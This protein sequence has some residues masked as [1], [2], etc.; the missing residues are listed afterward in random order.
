MPALA[1]RIARGC[2][3][4]AVVLGA[5]ILLGWLTD[6]HVLTRVLPG[7]PA[8]S[9]ITAVTFMFAGLSLAWPEPPRAWR[10]VW[11]GLTAALGARALEAWLVGSP[12]LIDRFL[13]RFDAG[14]VPTPQTSVAML[15]F[16]VGRL[17][18]PS[19]NRLPARIGETFIGLCALVAVMTGLGYLYEVPELIGRGAAAVP[20]PTA[21]GLSLLTW[22]LLATTAGRPPLVWLS[23]QGVMRRVGRV[24]LPVA[25]LTPAVV[26]LAAQNGRWRLGYSADTRLVLVTSVM[27]AALVGGV[28]V[29]GFAIARAERSR[30]RAVQHLDATFHHLPAA[31]SLRDPAGVFL[32]ANRRFAEDIKVDPDGIVGRTMEDVLP[33]EYLHWAREDTSAAL[34]T[35]EATHHE[36]ELDL[37][38]GPRVY[39]VTRY[40]VFDTDGLPIG[41]GTFSL[42]ITERKN[43]ERRAAA[44]AARIETF[45]E[46][47]PDANLVIDEGGVIRYANRRV[48][49]VLGY[50]VDEVVGQRI[51]L[52]VP[53]R[54]R[55]KHVGL[56]EHYIEDPVLRPMAGRD[57]R[58]R[59]RDGHDVPVEILL[60]PVETDEGR[61]TLAA[62][63]DVSEQRAAENALRAAEERYRTDLELAGIVQR[64]LLPASPPDFSG[65]ELAAHFS[66]AGEVGGDFYDWWAGDGFLRL[67]LADVMGKGVGAAII[68]AGVRAVLTDELEAADAATAVTRAAAVLAADLNSTGRFVTCFAASVEQSSGRVGWADAGH[69]LALVAGTSGAQWL[70]GG[71][72]P[73]G[74]EDDGVWAEHVTYLAPGDVLLAVSDGLLDHFGGGDEEIEQIAVRCRREGIQA[75]L[76]V[77]AAELGQPSDDLT[78]VALRRLEDA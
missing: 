67:V 65:Y 34:V 28:T 53:E 49:A 62:V 52:L 27:T 24:L 5:A 30:E 78:I 3:I 17:L 77:L 25:V 39:D 11:A 54:A 38:D 4:A 6:L 18:F 20:I 68:S 46:S 64:R 69:G 14:G 19:S 37:G 57:L 22:G 8:T 43:L 35:R 41:V 10:W 59:H 45:L 29:A 2:G 9:G 42:D 73:L 15:C 72:L 23:A 21:L 36:Y 32:I 48:T 47:A 40:P 74:V 58:A 33:P 75:V 60:G 13:S 63:R 12:L 1:Q 16:G 44:A 26:G 71:D 50:A 7:H 31:M 56:R 70:R 76:P 55:D 51:E 66:P 61:W